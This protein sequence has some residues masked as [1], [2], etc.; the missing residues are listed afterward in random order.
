MIYSITRKELE[1]ELRMTRL[2]STSVTT[3][4]KRRFTIVGPSSS[5]PTISLYNNEQ[6][7]CNT[8]PS[9]PK[10][11]VEGQV[12]LA[13]IDDM[14]NLI[15]I[16]KLP[17]SLFKPIIMVHLITFDDDLGMDRITQGT[18]ILT[19]KSSMTDEQE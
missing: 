10:S 7:T 1:T 11:N 9:C 16:H 13:T 14:L 3:N 6:S 12:F 15:A 4:T 8:T 2:G 17:K 18:I 19:F 5:N